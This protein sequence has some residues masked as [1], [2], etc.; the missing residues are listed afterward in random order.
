LW[1]A[2]NS[3]WVG[4]GV[5]VRAV[6]LGSWLALILCR[7][8]LPGRR[9]AFWL[10]ASLVFLPLY[11]ETAAWE[12][13]FGMLG[14]HS[15][16][17]GI[18]REPWLQ[19][20]DAVVWIHSL[21]SVPWVMLIVSA[22]LVW[23]EPELEEAALLDLA[24][25]RVLM[26]VTLRRAWPAVIVASV[27]ILLVTM[28]EMVVTDIYQVRTLAEELYTGYALGEE[29]ATAVSLAAACLITGSLTGAA[30]T[31]L[32]GVLSWARHVSRRAPVVFRLG[33]WRW[34][35]QLTLIGVLSLL[36]VVPIG[37]L[38]Y[39]AGLVVYQVDDAAVRGWSMARCFELLVPW[40]STYRF[41]AAWEFRRPLGWTVLIG[42]SAATL[43]VAIALPLGWWARRDGWRALPAVS[44]AAAGLGV[45]GPLVGVLLLQLFSA[46]D[47]PWLVWLR[48]QSI[49]LPVLAACWQCL[50]P[51][52]LICWLAMRRVSQ[53]LLDAATVDG[54][55]GTDRFLQLGVATRMPTITV[56]W[57]VAL[58]IACGELPASILVVPAGITTVPIRVFGLMHA[59]V[60]NQAA[61]L[62][63]TSIVQFLLLAAVVQR[64]VRRSQ[65]AGLRS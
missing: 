19:G 8:D 29:D 27:W 11:L 32:S 43:A 35:V 48:D 36:V 2:Y 47:R 52:V 61:A 30:M 63:L 13:G 18:T 60:A 49:L 12:A 14:W 34:P 62:C 6:P 22:A 46:G 21:W 20:V 10:V 5:C 64:I 45:M 51:V 31:V 53:S 7:T 37:N 1:L 28:S 17:N 50:P 33:R 9:Q 4:L 15:V 54:A 42:A 58:A 40:P 44:F 39:Q 57:L 55:R 26:R 41:S 25:G 59:G 56:A 16:A 65:L 38:L 3:V 23:S 24:A